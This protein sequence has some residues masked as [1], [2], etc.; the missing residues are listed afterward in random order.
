MKPVISTLIF[1]VSLCLAMSPTMAQ[2]LSNADSK[3][4]EAAIQAFAHEPDIADV[5]RQV[6]QRRDIDDDNVDRWTRRARWAGAIPRIQGQVSWL[7]QRDTRNRYRENISADETGQYEPN[8]AQHYLY[9][10]LRLRAIYSLRLNFDPSELLFSSSEMAIQREVRNR[11]STADAL[12]EEVTNLY[13]ARRR[14]QLELHLFGD[15]D[16]EAAL[17]RRIQIEALTARIDG[18]TGGWFRQRL[19][20]ESP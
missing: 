7:D 11:W 9:D 4:L 20:E 6:L 15:D 17:E 1:A 2:A 3:R 14:H 16:L 5:Q 8:N 10:D 18:L 13:F 19:E 12:V